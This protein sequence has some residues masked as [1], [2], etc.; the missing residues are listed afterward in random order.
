M[1]ENRT[2]YIAA[3]AAKAGETP[4]FAQRG[5]SAATV[6]RFCLGYDPE[7]DCVVLPCDGGH[8]VRRSVGEKR[9]LNEK[10]VPS[11]CFRQTCSGA[12]SRSLWWRGC[13][14]PCPPRSWAITAAP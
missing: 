14:T 4:Y 8:M 10:G 12:Q 5:L 2:A 1:N 7:L 13:S 6:S 9:Y 3:C 11:P